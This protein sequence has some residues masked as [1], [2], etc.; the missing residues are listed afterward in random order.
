MTY[1]IIVKDADG[2]KLGEFNTFRSLKFGKRLNNYGECSFEI[3]VNDDKASSL[4]GLRIYTIEIYRIDNDNTSVLLWAGEQVIRSGN[5]DSKG[6]GWATISCYDW[7]EQLNSRYTTAEVIYTYQNG[8]TIAWDLID[9]TQG[10]TNGD[11]GIVSGTLEA[12][13]FREKKYTNQNIMEAIISLANLQN[14]FDFE[15][16]NSKVF[17]VYN[18][19]GID[20]RSTSVLEYGT[21]IQ[22]IRISED[23][24]K[25]ITRAIILGQTS[26]ESD[27]VRIERD[28]TSQQAI[29][30][31]REYPMSQLEVSTEA[32]LQDTGDAVNKKYGAPLTK[33]SLD[34]VRSATPTIADFALGDVL[35]LKVKKGIYNIDESVRVFEWNVAYNTD[36]TESL[37]LTLGNFN[38]G[39]FS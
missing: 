33:Y 13:T 19:L 38:L 20:R 34:I 25:P 35:R 10:D 4:I 2:A 31:L 30:G 27:P 21:N 22:S 32:I 1:R 17:N 5:L 24:S 14:G 6:G 18:F 12:T 3:P 15:I 16:T 26:E 28:D 9:T 8:T 11:L 37:S 39:D 23:F 29:Y 7:L 36:N